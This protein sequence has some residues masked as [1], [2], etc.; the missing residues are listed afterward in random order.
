MTEFAA[1]VLAGGGGRRMGD[2]DKPARTVAGRPMVLRVLDAVADASPRVV[3]GSSSDL[4]PDAVVTRE[5]PPGGGPVAA[6]GAGIAV[7]SPAT[8]I[9]ALL[10]ADLPLLDAGAV[11]ML[12]RELA[13]GTD[14]GACFVD[15]SGRLQMLCGVWRAPALRRAL[16]RLASIRDGVLTG[17]SMRGLVAGLAVTAVRWFGPGLPPWF[18]CDTDED[19]RRAEEW[20][21]EHA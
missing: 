16:A 15:E 14:D 5:R 4:P 12:R 10:A 8:A 11:R 17:A 21:H 9:V 3:V 18:D 2:P 13:A 1:I 6:T 19:L 20:A 7:L